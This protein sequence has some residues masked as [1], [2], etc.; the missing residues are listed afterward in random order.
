MCKLY[1]QQRL[2]SKIYEQLIQLDTKKKKKRIGISP[3]RHFYR[4]DIWKGNKYMKRCSKSLI[5]E[6]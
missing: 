2:T 3:N 5:R 4:E 1:D 6:V